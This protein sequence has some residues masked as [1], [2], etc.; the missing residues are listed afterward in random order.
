MQFECGI[1]KYPARKLTVSPD[2]AGPNEPKVPLGSCHAMHLEP[3]NSA[4]LFSDV[5][6]RHIQLITSTV[7]MF[8][9]SSIF[10]KPYLAWN[11]SLNSPR[12]LPLTRKCLHSC[13]TGVIVVSSGHD[14]R[15]GHHIHLTRH[16]ASLQTDTITSTST[17]SSGRKSAPA[18]TPAEPQP[19]TRDHEELGAPT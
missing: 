6:K 2:T 5:F 10:N 15:H 19:T 4:F 3:P 12:L 8:P 11:A 13:S 17:T 14:R 7:F 16:L 9:E 18:K 1:T